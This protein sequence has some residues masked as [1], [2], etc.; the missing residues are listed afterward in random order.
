MYTERQIY[1]SLKVRQCEKCAMSTD[2]ETVEF[3]NWGEDDGQLQL[4]LVDHV[5]FRLLS[6]L[7]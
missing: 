1:I 7:V 5:L 4:S 3:K 6:T 2:I